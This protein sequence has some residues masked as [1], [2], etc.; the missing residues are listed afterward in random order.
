[1]LCFIYIL[2]YDVFGGSLMLAKKSF[3]LIMP[4]ELKRAIEGESRKL[5]DMAKKRVSMNSI[6]NSLLEEK[7]KRYSV[8]E[9]ANKEYIPNELKSLEPKNQTIYLKDETYNGLNKIAM[10]IMIDKGTRVTLTSII[11]TFLKERYL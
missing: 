3:P 2:I 5:T 9:L 4:Y 6:I 8:E 10:K 11:N 1:M 7:L